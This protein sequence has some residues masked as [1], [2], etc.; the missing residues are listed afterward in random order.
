MVL[1]IKRGTRKQKVNETLS[2]LKGAKRLDAFKYCGILKLKEDPMEI[3]K[4]LRNE[5]E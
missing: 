5:W 2:R 3:Q 4:R 1:I